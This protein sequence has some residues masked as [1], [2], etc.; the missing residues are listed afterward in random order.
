MAKAKKVKAEVMDGKR[1]GKR[2]KS[3]LK[4]GFLNLLLKIKLVVA[5]ALDLIDLV[6]AN[7]PLVNTLWDFVTFLVLM[8]TLRNKWLAFAAFAE[9][10]LVGLPMLG[11]ID[12]FIPIATI[13]TIIDIA[14][15]RLQRKS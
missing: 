11:Q 4:E 13:L 10:P 12:A 2:K 1:E 3:N 8:I 15:T 5:I 14:E 7:I 9:L 6:L